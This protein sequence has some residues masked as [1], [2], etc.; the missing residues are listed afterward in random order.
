MNS[1]QKNGVASSVYRY[2]N[3]AS[4]ICRADNSFISSLISFLCSTTV[5]D[6]WCLKW[7]S[8]LLLYSGGLPPSKS[9]LAKIIINLLLSLFCQPVNDEW[10]DINFVMVWERCRRFAVAVFAFRSPRYIS[11]EVRRVIQHLVTH[12]NREIPKYSFLFWT[13]Q[14]AYY[15]T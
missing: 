8:S 1:K 2:F 6:R 10:A 11:V 13:Y 3:Y 5:F 15:T 12:G 4:F 7:N 14:T 9:F